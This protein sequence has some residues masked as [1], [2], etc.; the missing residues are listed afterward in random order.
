MTKGNL[1]IFTIKNNLII[2]IYKI[3]I[4]IT[5]ITFFNKY[6]IKISVYKN[7]RMK[8]L[9]MLTKSFNAWKTF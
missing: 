6:E 8:Y 3:Y 1:S 4:L 9:T 7:G 2:I 5:H